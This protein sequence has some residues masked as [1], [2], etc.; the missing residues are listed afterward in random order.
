MERS[1]PQCERPA[2]PVA[3][4]RALVAQRGLLEQHLHFS[5]LRLDS[6]LNRSG[7]LG[8]HS[9]VLFCSGLLGQRSGLSRPQSRPD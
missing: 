7:P 9:G 2:L 4:A 8:Q 5:K 3:M 1:Q 6:G